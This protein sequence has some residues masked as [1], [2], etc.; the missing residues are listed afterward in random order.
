M[1]KQEENILNH[2][3]KNMSN[4]FDKRYKINLSDIDIY[5]GECYGHSDI[6]LIPSPSLTNI[7][8]KEYDIKKF[9]KD[10]DNK[11]EILIFN[12]DEGLWIEYVISID[13]NDDYLDK[14][15]LPD[16]KLIDYRVIPKYTEDVY[17]R[18]WYYG[19][20]DDGYMIEHMP[21]GGGVRVEVKEEHKLLLLNRIHDVISKAIDNGSFKKHVTHAGD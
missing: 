3:G 10:P 15:N 9:I 6:L 2:R 4:L 7:I 13:Q 11:D 17:F 12:F 14:F 5:G 19:I 8:R 21:D 20:G 1:T 16:E 18:F